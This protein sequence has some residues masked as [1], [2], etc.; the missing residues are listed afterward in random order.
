MT[1]LKIVKYIA[2]ALFCYIAVVGFGLVVMSA[3]THVME[4]FY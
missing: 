2:L 4:I 1:F 3:I